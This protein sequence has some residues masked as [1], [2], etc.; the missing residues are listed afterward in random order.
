MTES[1]VDPGLILKITPP[2]LRR[3]LL[4]RDRLRRLAIE[5]QDASVFVVEAPAGHGKTSLL[6]QWRLDWLQAGTVVAWMSLDADD[7]PVSV[8]S[9]VVLGLQRGTGRPRFGTEALEAVRHGAGPVPAITSLLAEI[10]ETAAATVLMFD[11]C[12]RARGPA[13]REVLDYLLHNLPPNLQIVLGSRP[14][15]P[16]ET[17][18]L[19]GQGSLRRVGPADLRFEVAE[20]IRFLSTRLGKRVG[21]DGCARLHDLVEGWPLGLQLAAAAME[22]AADPA[23]ML[24]TFSAAQDDTTRQLFDGMLNAL[25][26]P[27]ADFATRCS[28]LDALHPSLC[29]AVTGDENAGLHLHHLLVETPLVTATESGEWLR[30]HPLAREYLRTRAASRLS[31][32]ERREANLRAWAWLAERGFPARAAKHALNAGCQREALSLIAGSLNTEFELGHLGTVTE[33][34]ARIPPDEIRANLRLQLVWVWVQVLTY[35]SA[36]AKP[37]ARTLLEDPSVDGWARAEA[38]LALGTAEAYGDN[39]SEG[40]RYAASFPRELAGARGRQVFVNVETYFLIFEG[41]TE[42]ARRMQSGISDRARFPA[43]SSFGDFF[44]G[45]S[46]LWE[47]RPALAE[48]SLR[49]ELARWESEVGRRGQWACMLA[50]LLGPALWMRGERREALAVL[51]MR[52]DVIEQVSFPDGILYS[53]RT[54]AQIAA[55][56][57]DETRAFS[58]LEA[59]AALGAARRLARCRCVSLAERVRMH[60]AG[61]RPSQAIALLAELANLVDGEGARTGFAPLLRLDHSIAQAIVCVATD[62]FRAAEGHLQTAES[63]AHRLNRG[64]EAVQ[65]LALRALV[66]DRTGRSPEPV[67]IEALSRAASGGLVRVFSDTLPDVL[68]LVRRLATAESYRPVDRGFIEGVLA[69]AVVSA[70]EVGAIRA[71]PA[72]V[73]ASTVLTPKEADVLRLLAGGKANKVIAAELDLSADTIKWHVK[74][75]FS[76]LNAGSREHAVERARMLGLLR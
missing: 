62:D 66:L 12:E 64:Y 76:K 42:E 1:A 31:D 7:S 35:Q 49:I 69:A 5:G 57:G 18:D 4:A 14:P 27:L 70:E 25:P 55:A 60:A 32:A 9:G 61:R 59:L 47:G 6:A 44:A 19:L 28:L 68:G 33:W 11:N 75:L 10:A 3:S 20:S 16:L 67:L 38:N 21:A 37:V 50:G 73:T 13:V 39:I 51:A 54:L 58:Y 40:A 71:G 52:L 36:R 56:E 34:L 22:Q 41:A 15:L 45:L 63:I 17:I 53:F 8:I 30:F 74:K 2:K 29:E 48:Q 46:Y 24:A 26:A 43:V 65:I 72:G 23:R